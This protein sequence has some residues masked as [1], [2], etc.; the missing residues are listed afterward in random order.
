MTGMRE[1]NIDVLIIGAGPAGMA[2][3]IAARE[4]GIDSLLI[5]DREAE[6]G[7]ILKQ[8]VHNGFGL[9]RFQEELTGPEYAQR[10]INRLRELNVSVHC[11]TMVIDIDASKRVTAVSRKHGVQVF[12]AK[13]I[14]LAMGCRERPRGALAIPGT[15]P[16]GI[17]SA[18]T[19]QKLVNMQGYM[20]GKRVIILGSGDI[21]LIMARR[22]ILQGAKVLA[23]AEIMPYSSGLNRNIV[24][25]LH[26]YDIPLL[27]RHTVIDIQGKERLE[28]V[29]VAKVDE[30][31]QP[32]PG[33]EIQYACDTL[34]LSVGLIPEN[35]LTKLIGAE[36]SAATQGAVVD[37]TLQTNIDGV[38]ACGNVLHVHDLVDFVSEESAKAGRAAADYVLGRT[39]KV[40]RAIAVLDGPGVRGVVPQR[41]RF[42]DTPE[43]VRFM[44]RPDK[45]YQKVKVQVLDG[46]RVAYSVA[47]RILSPGEMAEILLPADTMQSFSSESISIRISG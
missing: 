32:I 31:L 40:A 18:G 3:A 15:R 8:C 26:D 11:E 36:M 46:E 35:E 1:T 6:I 12:L 2:A 28:S 13:A 7:G 9:H 5:L 23:C 42:T 21:G 45:V 39:K 41:L 29:T 22:M 27:L 38:F 33:T 34:L 17:F 47:K 30:H 44:F 4:Q 24:Q 14:I 16:A 37:N 20:P 43:D 25:C 19:A 10:D